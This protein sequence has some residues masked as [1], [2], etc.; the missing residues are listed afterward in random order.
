MRGGNLRTPWIAPKSDRLVQRLVEN[1]HDEEALGYAHQ[2]GEDDPKAYAML[3]ERVGSEHAR[4]AY[5][6]H[7]LAEAAQ[8]LVD[9]ARRRPPRRAH[10]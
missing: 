3:L 6:A 7:W 9:D 5:A 1:P 4:P 8:R 2:A 10:V